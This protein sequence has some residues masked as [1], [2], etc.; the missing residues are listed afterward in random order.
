MTP[1]AFSFLVTGASRGGT[2]ILAALL[3]SH[4]QLEAGF[5]RHYE[6]LVGLVPETAKTIESRLSAFYAACKQEAQS[7]P[8][9][10]GNKLTVEHIGALTGKGIYDDEDAIAP[11]FSRVADLKHIFIL[12]DGRTCIRSK[13]I[14]A[15]ETFDFA[16]RSW[17]YSVKLLHA[18]REGRV[19]GEIVKFEDLILNPTPTLERICDYLG[20]EY[21]PEMLKGTEHP[22]LL[23]E[24]RRGN[25]EAEKAK[26]K[27][28]PARLMRRIESEL[29]YCGY[30]SRTEAGPG[31]STADTLE[32]PARESDLAWT[33][34]RYIAGLG[35]EIEFEHYHRYLF[36]VQFCHGRDVLDIASGEGY[37]SMLLS[38]IARSVIGIDIDPAT[39]AHAN[40][41]YGRDNLK[42]SEGACSKIPLADKSVDVVVSFETIEHIEEHDAFLG[43][44]RRVLRPSGCVVIS[45]P[46]RDV[47]GKPEEPNPFHVRELAKAEFHDLLTRY[48][49]N[50]EV[51][52]Q[53]TLAGSLILPDRAPRGGLQVFNRVNAHAFED[54]SDV[55]SAPFL[56]CVASSAKLPRIK[57]GVLD[58]ASFLQDLR[59]E[60]DLLAQQLAHQLER[61]KSDSHLAKT[62]RE[63]E[64][65]L[66][67]MLADRDQQLSRADGDL[68][69]LLATDADHHRALSEADRTIRTLMANVADRERKL[70]AADADLRRLTEEVSER[71]RRLTAADA[72]LR[73]LT[74]AVSDRDRRLTAADADL[75]RLT[76]AVSDRDGRLTAADADL[77][78]LTE[79]VSE[80]DRRLTG[81]AADL[82]R[83][84]NVEA[85][86]AVRDHA[87]SEAD[88]RIEQLTGDVAARDARLAAAQEELARLAAELEQQSQRL[89]AALNEQ[90]ELLAQRD[91]QEE[92]LAAAEADLRRLT[93]KVQHRDHQLGLLE[94][95]IQEIEASKIWRATNAVNRMLPK[96]R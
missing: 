35:G 79:E 28:L 13:L 47:Y 85:D 12:R 33:G 25:L 30:I 4:P 23:P 34:E 19:S 90:R 29:E 7:Q 75:R 84:K 70:K 42:F 50:I 49:P 57:W 55:Q 3:G 63:R 45:T 20:V 18:I 96:K 61:R 48:F 46:D 56:V 62:T 67:Q 54:R 2:S 41:A 92:K 78:R 53:K 16:A 39:V 83:S 51:G 17:L 64:R 37:G 58:D 14:R 24:Y 8:K 93:G 86:L 31:T 6:H 59:E 32:F 73:R 11:F 69:R 22:G 74:E 44:V 21:S 66:H 88:R 87:L 40:K 82:Q 38:G 89:H 15:G 76:E 60:R 77:R 1:G 95:R 80:R 26:A 81:A 68:Q 10:W 36:A 71:E 27:P 91:G 72:D 43:E 5:E 52:S 65:D 94:R 9:V